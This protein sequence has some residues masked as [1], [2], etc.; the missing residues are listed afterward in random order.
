MNT[1]IPLVDCSE[2][3]LYRDDLTEVERE[4]C[5]QT[6]QLQDFIF[7]YLDRYK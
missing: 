7:I 2:A 6:A 5:S 3:H 4:L 1:L